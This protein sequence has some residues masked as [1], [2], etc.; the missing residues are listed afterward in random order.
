MFKATPGLAY[1]WLTG[2]GN[3]TCGGLTAAPNQT[4]PTFPGGMQCV[5]DS[6]C[7][8]D[9]PYLLADDVCN[10]KKKGYNTKECQ[11]DG[12]DC[13]GGGGGSWHGM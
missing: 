13:K 10:G 11:A 1:L 9:L 12:G 8:V 7:D 5:D 6:V 3:T 4:Q 2:N